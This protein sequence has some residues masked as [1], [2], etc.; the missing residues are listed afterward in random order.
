MG[1]PLLDFFVFE[2]LFS[3]FVISSFTYFWALR[4][5]ESRQVSR[6]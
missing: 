4:S 3:F 1:K 6:E 2:F 5:I